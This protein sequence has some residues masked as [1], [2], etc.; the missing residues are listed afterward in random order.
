MIMS[1][2]PQEAELLT[3]LPTE[4]RDVLDG[5]LND[6]AGQR[7]FPVAYLDPTEEEAETEYRAM[8]HPDLMRQ[9]LD[10]LALVAASLERATRRDESIELELTPDDVQAWLGILNDVRLVLGTRLGITE[11]DN[12]I[13]LDDPR[14]G[15]YGAYSWLTYLQGELI[16]QLW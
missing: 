10:A 9:R 6:A 12:E 13:Q 14:A 4:L 7:L 5:P 15:A 16:D 1:L 8:V 11:D 3:A 2:T